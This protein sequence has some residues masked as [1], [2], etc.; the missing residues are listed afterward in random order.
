MIEPYQ[1]QNPHVK[2]NVIDYNGGLAQI[3]A[4][5]EAKNVTWQVVDMTPQRGIAGCDEGILEPIDASKLDPAEDGTP[6][7]EDFVEGGLLGPG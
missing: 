3:K 1:Q 7:T 4:Q 5:I 6:A 2:I